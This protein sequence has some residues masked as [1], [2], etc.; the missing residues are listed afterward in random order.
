MRISFE[1]ACQLLQSNDIVA[2]PTE[3]VYGLAASLS[4]EAGITKIFT[5]KGRPSQNPL[6]IHVKNKDQLLPYVKE[7]PP[8]FNELTQAFWPGPLTLVVPIKPNCIST[9]VTAGLQTAAFRAPAHPLTQAL[10]TVA[11]PL[12]APSANLS[13]QPSPTTAHHV[14]QDLG[15]D[16]PVLNGGPSS[17][18]LES[19]IL[20][21]ADS[22]WQIIR[23]GALAPESFT[24]ILGYQP[25]IQ[26]ENGHKAICPGQ[27]FRHYAPNAKLILE[28]KPSNFT[29]I[30]GFSDRH[31][32]KGNPLILLGPLSDPEEVAKRLYDVLRQLDHKHLQEVW[33]DMDF[34]N[35][36]LWITIRER[37]Q[38]AAGKI[39]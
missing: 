15:I 38:K 35:H 10:L 8:Q 12:V 21:F 34:P 25:S 9:K 22:N 24:S 20:Y 3:T 7:L 11:G 30:L 6:I 33:V 27:L 37:I 31:Y 23:L 32:P 28:G 1:K 4:S 2:I 5:T 13:G 17:K 36:G 14:E 19:T 26:F 39:I 29:P 18:G 16:F